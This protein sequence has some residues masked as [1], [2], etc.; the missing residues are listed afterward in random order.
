M[1]KKLCLVQFEKYPNKRYLFE[2]P[3]SRYLVA[4]AY[5]KVEGTKD[6]GM[7]TDTV[8]ICDDCDTDVQAMQFIIA[9]NEN[10]PL[11]KITHIVTFAREI[12]RSI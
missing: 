5:C 4:G 3:M 8:S 11:K 10:R 2:A 1:Y 9:M 6:I 7:I 12:R